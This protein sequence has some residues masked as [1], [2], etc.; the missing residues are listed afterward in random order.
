MFIAL[1]L[2]EPVRREIDVWRRG[3]LDDPALRFPERLRMDLLFLGNR[4]RRQVYHYLEAIREL[5]VKAP[6]PLIELADA[7]PRGQ[8]S[9]PR[10]FAL[11][12]HSTGAEVLQIGLRSI[13]DAER[14]TFFE[15]TKRPFWP[16]VTV[17][18]V[19]TEEGESRR[20]QRLQDPPN[21]V[22][23]ARLRTPF[24]AES[25]GLYSS[26]LRSME[27]ATSCLAKPS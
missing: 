26:E 22:L 7:V 14:L 15:P 1:D 8:P 6:A 5:C 9:R 10:I 20:P 2:P 19:R 16:H 23:P 25:V 27:P 17:A 12:V 18:R 21:L 3:A 11:P 24:R 13:L 4:P